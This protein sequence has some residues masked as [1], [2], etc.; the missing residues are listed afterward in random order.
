[1]FQGTLTAAGKTLTVVRLEGFERTSDRIGSLKRGGLYSWQSGT[2]GSTHEEQIDEVGQEPPF[3]LRVILQTTDIDTDLTVT[4]VD[5]QAQLDIGYVAGSDEVARTFSGYVFRCVLTH[6]ANPS[7]EN[8]ANQYEADLYPWFWYL[9]YSRR[10][11]HWTNTTPAKIMDDVCGAYGF[12]ENQHWRFTGSEADIALPYIVQHQESD[13]AFLTGLF[14]RLHAT[15]FV[16]HESDGHVLTIGSGKDD[17]WGDEVTLDHSTDLP[18]S[19]APVVSGLAVEQKTVPTVAKIAN[20]RRALASTSSFGIVGA[21]SPG[22]PAEQTLSGGKVVFS[23]PADVTTQSDAESLADKELADLE[24]VQR[25]F[26]GETRYLPLVIGQKLA[27]THM[28]DRTGALDGANAILRRL[29]H[30]LDKNGYAAWL[31]ATPP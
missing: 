20:R 19:P 1:M 17:F 18:G 24:I 5:K 9:S 16:A 13:Y 30:R 2:P 31:E 12:A 11:R 6:V 4:L 7:V 3:H 26:S 14:R 28:F 10:N 15:W 23:Y 22:Q 25:L 8:P 21:T 29:Y 27:F